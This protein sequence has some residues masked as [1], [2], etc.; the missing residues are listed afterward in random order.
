MKEGQGEDKSKTR[1]PD[2]RENQANP[3]QLKG[4]EAILEVPYLPQTCPQFR[5]ANAAPPT[6][7]RHRRRR[8][9]AADNADAAPPTTRWCKGIYVNKFL[10]FSELISDE[11]CPI[12]DPSIVS[13][14]TGK[15]RKKHRSFTGLESKQGSSTGL[16]SKL[17]SSTSLVSKLGSP[18]GPDSKLGCS[19]EEI[20][21]YNITMQL[22]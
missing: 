5:I 17:G 3:Q 13:L 20:V 15:A 10:N 11:N 4:P 14:I 6:M 7:P 8:R 9:R 2:W 12:Y 19:T 22:C 18:T 1:N 21:D 16:E